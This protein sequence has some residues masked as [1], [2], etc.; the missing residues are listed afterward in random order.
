MY[1]R[2]TE[3]ALAGKWVIGKVDEIDRSRDNV[4]RMVTVKYFNGH[5]KTPEHTLRTV[6]KLVKLWNVDEMH[7][8]E[9]L[10][11]LQ[12]KFGPIPGVDSGDQVDNG[13][14]QS[15]DNIGGVYW[16]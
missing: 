1:F 2:K 15:Q 11:E 3:S 4:I 8:D 9:D 14:A 16:L 13:A 7:L 6:R 10:A 5:N 12:R